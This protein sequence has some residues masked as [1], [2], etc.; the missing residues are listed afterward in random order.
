MKRGLARSG[1][2]AALLV[3]LAGASM[4]QQTPDEIAQLKAQVQQLQQQLQTLSKR[5]DEVTTA[6][7]ADGT[8]AATTAAANGASDAITP[9]PAPQPVRPLIASTTPMI[10]PPPP[11]TRPSA[12]P[13]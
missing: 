11:V 4:A 12:S 5:L 8:P 13:H 9:N 1:T 10:A 6:K 2:A 7:S 3:L